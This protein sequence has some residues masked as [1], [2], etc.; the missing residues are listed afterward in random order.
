ML[1]WASVSDAGSSSGSQTWGAGPHFPGAVQVSPSH[2]AK[3]LQPVLPDAS[4]LLLTADPAS[5]WYLSVA[6]G[7]KEQMLG[8]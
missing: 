8:T 4:S 5:L 1:S 7:I 6:S 3:T 2:S